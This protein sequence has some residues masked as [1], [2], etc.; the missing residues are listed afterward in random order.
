MDRIYLDYA[1]TAPTDPEILKAMEPYFF[2]E[3]GNASSPH[4]FGREGKKATEGARE[5]LAGFIGARPEEIV[6]TSGATEA[7]NQA[8]F[9]TARRLRDRG[10]HVI[11]SDVE[12][13]SVREPAEALEREGFEVT[14]L[15]VD[16][17]GMVD[18]E[19]VRRALKDTTILVAV[20]HASNE[21]GTLQ[22][23]AEVGKV[24][25][26]TEAVFLVDAVQ[27]LG[28]IPVSVEEL[29]CDLLTLSAHKFYGPKGVGALYVRQGTPVTSFI[30][31]GD[32]ERGR[33]ASTQ[34]VPG[35]V[36]LGK[37]VELCREK[38]TAEA[39]EQTALRDR[40]IDGI[41]NDV[42]GARL[43]GHR[44]RRLPNNAHFS[45][46][47]VDGEALLMSLDMEG[48]A[49]SQGSACTSGALEPSHVLRA[50]GLPDEAAYSALRIT[51]GRWT[52]AA[53]IEYIL[54]KL[55]KIIERLRKV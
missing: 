12:H 21:I 48:M 41:L 44:T 20:M 13:H 49:C 40:L 33:R 43:N 55:P 37:A 28:H 22:P 35:I 16:E 19:A 6:F 14:Y 34:N 8:V 29:D 3:F 27:T 36:G 17:A 7:N 10:K 52:T 9:G 38:M 39:E 45:F 53:H 23:V 54:E 2:E 18:P 26:E 1:S 31:G 5:M 51:I 30:L 4:A 25:R 46:P 42:E 11:I 32:Q 47:G 15:P 24:V 50:I